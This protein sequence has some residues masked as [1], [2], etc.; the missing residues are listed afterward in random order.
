[1]L[2]EHTVK[3]IIPALNEAQAIGR[4]LE[5]LPSWID[6]I[7]VVDN[8]STDRTAEIATRHG[9]RVIH[10]PKRGYGQ[11][12]HTGVEA[13]G[14]ADILLFVDADYSDYPEEAGDLVRPIAEGKF[15]L[16]IG[17]RARGSRARGALTVQQRFGNWL[18]CRLIAFFWGYRYTDLG[19]FRAVRSS[20]LQALG[21]QDRG[22]GWTT[23]MQ[24]RAA[25]DGYRIL[26]VPVSYRPRI[27]QSKISGTVSGVVGAG[28][29]ILLTI[30]RYAR[31]S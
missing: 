27:G 26:E 15:D 14:S 29:K 30:F 5:A 18:A 31:G 13:A 4:V 7:I 17:S 28:S 10:E 24:I 21:M 16:V 11:A 3:V 20:V 12:C 22:Y 25:R 9:A 1:M 8:G 6:E 19:P 2:N 23:E